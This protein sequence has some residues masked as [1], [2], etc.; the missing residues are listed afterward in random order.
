MVHV[1]EYHVD[2]ALEIVTFVCCTSIAKSALALPQSAMSHG[3]KQQTPAHAIRPAFLA[4]RLSMLTWY[5]TLPARSS[6]SNKVAWASEISCCTWPGHNPLPC[7]L[8]SQQKLTLGADNLPQID[9]IDMV[10]ILEQLDLPNGGDGE[11]FFLS[12]HADLLQRHLISSLFVR[13]QVHLNVAAQTPGL[14]TDLSW[15]NKAGSCCIC[16]ARRE[17]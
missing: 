2:A 15:N 16:V 3:C 10:Q 17:S 11:A 1:V 13:C 9:D 8:T 6:R 12:V 7:C 5:A 14:A 4:V